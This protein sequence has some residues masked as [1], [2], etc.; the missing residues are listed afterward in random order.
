MDVSYQGDAFCMAKNCIRSSDWLTYMPSGAAAFSVVCVVMLFTYIGSRVRCGEK[1][2]PSYNGFALVL[3]TLSLFMRTWIQPKYSSATAF[4]RAS[5]YFNYACA[6]WFSMLNIVPYAALKGTG[7]KFLIGF[8]KKHASTKYFLFVHL[9]LLVIVIPAVI[10]MFKTVDSRGVDPSRYLL[11]F[12]I[13]VIMPFSLITIIFTLA[14]ARIGIFKNWFR[15][16]ATIARSSLLLMWASFMLSRMFL[17][18]DSPARDSEVMFYFF[19]YVP[20]LLMS[21]LPSSLPVFHSCEE[22][23]SVV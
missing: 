16:A 12:V 15:I 8:N 19:N 7:V 2:S 14:S 20:L 11:Q 6:I 21:V 10:I 17:S 23:D 13:Y 5:I 22:P 4:Y 1:E 3:L 9:I 18:L